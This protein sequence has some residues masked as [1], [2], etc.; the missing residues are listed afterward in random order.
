MENLTISI[1]QA[2]SSLR[3]VRAEAERHEAEIHYK[4][5]YRDGLVAAYKGIV[6]QMKHIVRL[7]D[8][9]QQ[10][11]DTW[12]KGD[13]TEI[14]KH[15]MWLGTNDIPKVITTRTVYET[16]RLLLAKAKGESA[17]EFSPEPTKETP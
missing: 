13:N 15:T 14:H 16:A 10:L 8:F 3:Y 5:G 9:V 2:E 6:G 11:V 7:E 12:G 1:K 17:E 4:I